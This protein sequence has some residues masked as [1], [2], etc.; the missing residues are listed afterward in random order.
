MGNPWVPGR[1]SPSQWEQREQRKLAARSLLSNGPFQ[2]SLMVF[3]VEKE[4]ARRHGGCCVL[5]GGSRCFEAPPYPTPVSN[6]GFFCSL[7]FRVPFIV[8]KLSVITE[9]ETE[10]CILGGQRKKGKGK[11]LG[12]PRSLCFQGWS[13]HRLVAASPLQWAGVWVTAGAAL[14]TLASNTQGVCSELRSGALAEAP[15]R[16]PGPRQGHWYTSKLHCRESG[17]WA[18]SSGP[19]RSLHTLVVKDLERS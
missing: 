7:V 14:P 18:R 1:S 10:C 19:S 13:S 15:V 5:W 12:G 11:P 3:A 8:S 4:A 2:R 16:A 6:L 9:L 17:C